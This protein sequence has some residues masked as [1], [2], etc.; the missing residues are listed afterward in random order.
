MASNEALLHRISVNNSQVA[1][2]LASNQHLGGVCLASKLHAEGMR[3][4]V[5]AVVG[6]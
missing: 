3:L 1:K 4:A 5:R 6:T 2:T